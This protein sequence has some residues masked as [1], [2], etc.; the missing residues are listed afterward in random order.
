MTSDQHTQFV[1][2]VDR[3]KGISFFG[4]N[5]KNS[6]PSICFSAYPRTGQLLVK[7]G[8]CSQ[9]ATTGLGISPHAPAAAPLRAHGTKKKIKRKQSLL[10]L[11]K[12]AVYR[13]CK[14]GAPAAHSLNR[15]AAHQDLV[16]EIL[17]EGNFPVNSA[18]FG[19]DRYG[20]GRS[21]AYSSDRTRPRWH[22]QPIDSLFCR[23]GNSHLSYVRDT[24]ICFWS[25]PGTCDD[26]PAIPY[27]SQA[28][29]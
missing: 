6:V 25:L 3:P 17:D 22:G 8:S 12:S 21:A 27:P 24:I 29:L 4:S 7:V 18:V 13:H 28:K 14:A 11:P 9:T 10:A 26:H 5:A 23:A 1:Q 16:Y 19:F 20:V 2:S 15:G